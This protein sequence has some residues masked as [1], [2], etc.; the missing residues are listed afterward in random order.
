M[1]DM[2]MRQVTL[3]YCIIN[4]L[5]LLGMKKKGFGSGK[6]NGYGGKQ[7]PGEDL[8][9]TATRELYEEA[10]IK[11]DPKDLE[12]V[13]EIEFYFRDVP[14]EKNWD[15]RV[16]VYF[17][18]TWDGEAMETEEM[19]PEWHNINSL[20]Y[21]KMWSGDII[22]LPRILRGEKIK[23]SITFEGT[24]GSVSEHNLSTV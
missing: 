22:W 9:F 10:K 14:K 21:E 23:G 4:D 24:G 17:L 2:Q 15:Q 12:K 5:I 8:G 6:I 7:R 16:N 18:R 20:S 1:T 13:A 19:K 11:G 3:V